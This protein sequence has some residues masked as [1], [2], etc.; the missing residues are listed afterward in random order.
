MLGTVL[1]VVVGATVLVGAWQAAGFSDEGFVS[2]GAVT[3][4]VL[5]ALSVAVFVSFLANA[6][7][8]EP[9]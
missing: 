5:G 8:Q 2:T 3:L 4:G 6:G 1:G 7:H 9:E